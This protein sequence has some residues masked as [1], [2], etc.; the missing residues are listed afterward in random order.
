M[1][2]GSLSSTSSFSNARYQLAA[3]Y[4]NG[5][6]YL[7]GGSSQTN[8][9]NDI[10]YG[11]VETNGQVLQWTISSSQLNFARSQHR[12]EILTTA[13]GKTY[14]AA[15]SGT[16][17]TPDSIPV[18]SDTIEVAEIYQ[19]GSLGQWY[20]CPFHLKGGRQWPAT[21]VVNNYLYVM[22]GRGS[23]LLNEMFNDVQ[24]APIQ[25]NGCPSPWATSSHQLIMPL[26]GHKYVALN[27]NAL[28][29][30]GGS[31]V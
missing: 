31:G 16:I 4:Y 1:L 26:Y 10:Q 15:I 7:V 13:L 23:L 22:G 30:F 27:S 18:L 11:H 9:L 8:L 14:L 28:I 29:I 25:D 19:D 3:T 2:P 17:L 6:I 24:F 12:L 21:S 5:Y 20:I